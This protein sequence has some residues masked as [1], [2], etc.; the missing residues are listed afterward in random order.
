MTHLSF[1][2][3]RE[4]R[5]LVHTS[6]E[7]STV[8]LMRGDMDRGLTFEKKSPYSRKSSSSLKSEPKYCTVYK[9]LLKL[10]H[11]LLYPYRFISRARGLGSV[12]V[13]GII[14]V[15][16]QEPG[17]AQARAPEGT[18]CPRRLKYPSSRSLLQ[19][20]R[21]NNFTPRRPPQLFC[22]RLYGYV[23]YLY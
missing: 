17:T 20:I 12:R 18:P 9:L 7:D 2:P 15:R 13:P 10:Y 1:V 3:P 23:Q 6:G 16:S 19:A 14:R 8:M 11:G 22:R 21:V 4:S 5:L